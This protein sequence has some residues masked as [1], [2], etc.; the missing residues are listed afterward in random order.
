MDQLK[1]VCIFDPAIDKERVTFPILEKFA[2]TRDL[3]KIAPFFK[4]GSK[5]TA[6]TIRRIPRSVM[7]RQVISAG[8]EDEKRLRAFQYGVISIEALTNSDGSRVN[9]EPSGTIDTPDGPL[10]YISDRELERVSLAESLEIGA[11]AW[12][13]NFLPLSIVDC[14]RLAPSSVGILGRLTYLLAD[15]SP[16]TV[17]LSNSKHSDPAQPG[18]E[19]TEISSA[20]IGRKSE[21]PMAATAEVGG[22]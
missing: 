9:W 3:A 16:T 20:S 12:D 13:F 18:K 6:F 15:A 19:S 1:T 14:Y 21:T 4:S 8:S 22:I 7:I 2:Q 10:I 17:A 11:V 5:P